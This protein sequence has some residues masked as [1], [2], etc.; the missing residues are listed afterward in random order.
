MD[1]LQARDGL[2]FD[3]HRVLDDEIKTVARLEDHALVDERYW[4]LRHESQLAGCQLVLQAGHI[5]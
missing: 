4:L 1:R 3:D 5:R 2:Y